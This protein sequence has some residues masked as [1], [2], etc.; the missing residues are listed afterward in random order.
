MIGPGSDAPVMVATAPVD[1]RKGANSL[2]ALVKAQYG[3]DPFSGVIYVFRVRRA[4]RVKLVG[5]TAR[6]CA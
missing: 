5:V 1:F 4:D 2:A 3:A 6:G